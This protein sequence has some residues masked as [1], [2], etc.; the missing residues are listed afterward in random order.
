MILREIFWGLVLRGMD[1]GIKWDISLLFLLMNPERESVCSVQR[2]LISGAA[3]IKWH[4][5]VENTESGG[6][7]PILKDIDQYKY[8]FKRRI[9]QLALPEMSSHD[10]LNGTNIL[11]QT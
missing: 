6:G 2:R 3:L 4:S 9:Q 11:Y 5:D 1:I 8:P 7:I 10:N